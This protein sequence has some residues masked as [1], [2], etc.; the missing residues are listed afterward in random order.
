M[1]LG[2]TV[3]RHSFVSVNR[4]T[5]R[6]MTLRRA[7]DACLQKG[8]P[9]V[10]HE[11][12]SPPWPPS[13]RFPMCKFRN[14]AD[15][16]V[17]DGL[18]ESHCSFLK[19]E[20]PPTEWLLLAHDEEYY[21]NFVDDTLDRTMW[22]RI[23]FSQRPDHVALVRR[24]CLEVAGTVL[25][26]RNALAWGLA[27]HTAGGTHHAHRSWGSGYTVFNDLAIA[28]KVLLDEK[29]VSRI[30]ICDL[31]V[32]QGDGTAEILSAEPRAFTF[33]VHCKSNFPFGFKCMTHLGHDKSD[34][35]I[36]LERDT[37]DTCYMAALATHL[38]VILE[39]H[40]PDLV[41][42]D[43][44]VDVHI[45]DD[46]GNLSVSWSG[47]RWRDD[48]V[49]DACLSRGIPIA[50]VAGGG[51]DRDAEHLAHRHAVVHH[52]AAAAWKRYKLGGP[53]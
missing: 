9:T 39:R 53:S 24:T 17:R 19:P 18:H 13:H 35:D 46:L 20:E 40:R 41:L 30:L 25:A 43:A 51:Y 44:G 34:L 3:L 37:G 28:A 1:D 38:P 14:L 42:Y 21:R 48:F 49:L 7:A 22:R 33:S 15:Q 16:L 32:H 4:C 23:G 12:Y 29:V 31:D 47:L 2:A 5:L 11:A 27:C 10:W 36:G 26:A 50:C 45:N 8:P 52:A 6:W